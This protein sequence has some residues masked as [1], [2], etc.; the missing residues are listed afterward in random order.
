MDELINKRA[1]KFRNIILG[2]GGRGDSN[3]NWARIILYRLVITTIH[4]TILR[5]QTGIS[6]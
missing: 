1:P 4:K 6:F 3:K 5:G 2:G